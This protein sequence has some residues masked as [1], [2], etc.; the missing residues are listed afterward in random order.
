MEDWTNNV[1]EQTN[2]LTEDVYDYLFG[3]SYIKVTK[4]IFKK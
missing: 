3:Y 2:L 1:V 4:Y